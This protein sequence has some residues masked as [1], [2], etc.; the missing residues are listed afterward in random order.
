M[1]S[2]RLAVAVRLLEILRKSYAPRVLDQL[3]LALLPLAFALIYASSLCLMRSSSISSSVSAFQCPWTAIH[4][5]SSPVSPASR[6]NGDLKAGLGARGGG[7][8]ARLLVD[9]L[10]DPELEFQ[11]PTTLV[12]D[13]ATLLPQY[14]FLFRP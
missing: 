4:S 8:V 12:I 5:S 14:P 11:L 10:V 6:R 3:L 7:D 1:N 2:L 13:Q 9:E